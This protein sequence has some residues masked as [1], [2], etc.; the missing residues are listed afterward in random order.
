MKNDQMVKHQPSPADIVTAAIEALSKKK[1]TRNTNEVGIRHHGTQITLPEHPEKMGVDEAIKHLE[2][3]NERLHQ[4]TSVNETIDAFP[5]DGARAFELAM[6]EMFGWSTPKARESFF[7]DIPPQVIMVETSH[8]VHEPVIWGQF[9]IPGLSQRLSCGAEMTPD[10]EFVFKINGA[11]LVKELELVRELAKTTRRIAKE[12]SIYKGKAIRVRLAPSGKLDATVP[13]AHLDLSGDDP[14]ILPRAIEAAVNANVFMPVEQTAKC[15]RLG[16]PTKRGI[17]AAGPPGTGK[18][19]M[20][21]HLAKKAVKNGW[22]YIL[23]ENVAALPET[24][25]FARRYTPCVLFVED[26]DHGTSGPRDAKLNTLLNTID[27]IASKN[28][29]IMTVC[30]SNDTSKID[31]TL[32][33]PGRFDAIIEF[34]APKDA[35]TIAKFIR[36]Y[37]AGKVAADS[38][39]TK[40][41]A[42]L[43]GAIPA[44]IREAVERAKL[45]A[46]ARG[47]EPED[48]TIVDDDIHAAIETMRGHIDFFT[49]KKN[50]EL[51]PE[52]VFG[53]ALIDILNTG[54]QKGFAELQTKISAEIEEQFAKMRR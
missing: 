27:G 53:K 49:S 11:C 15:K 46:I 3:I 51:S 43:E 30:T 24:I 25:K 29:D 7:G 18:T 5:L 47:V 9:Q 32:V 37:G 41:C 8:G 6:Q 38:D 12:Q 36:H 44:I 52:V 48:M 26:I 31:R 39:L 10:G 16:V 45:Y 1:N 35:E 28:L 14:L 17:I 20:A 54:T 33:R 42:A 22:T 40:S 2:N 13:P 19:L 50:I 21:K 4:T 34:P 23:V